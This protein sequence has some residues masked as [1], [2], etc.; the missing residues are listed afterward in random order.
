MVEVKK[1]FELFD[2]NHDGMIDEE[3]FHFSIHFLGL[4]ERINNLKAAE[5]KEMFTKFDI[6]HNGII[7]Y[8]GKLRVQ[9]SSY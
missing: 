9:S 7:S 5:V 3:E 8:A 2:L 1:A 4:S 6:D